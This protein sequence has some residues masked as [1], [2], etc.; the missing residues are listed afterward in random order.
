[1]KGL[2][3]TIS[4]DEF[5]TFLMQNLLKDKIVHIVNIN[6]VYKI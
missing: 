4:E 1:M 5:K 3:E 6:R 2:K